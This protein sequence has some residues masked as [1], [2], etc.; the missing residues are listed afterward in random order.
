MKLFMLS[1]MDLIEN[2]SAGGPR[3]FIGEF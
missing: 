2:F 1:I 3:F